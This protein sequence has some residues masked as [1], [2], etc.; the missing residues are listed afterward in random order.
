M[1]RHDLD[2]LSLLAGMIF[3]GTALVSLL[4]QGAGLESRWTWPVLLIVAGVAGLLATRRDPGPR[5]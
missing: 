1:P 5:P 4:T 3:A 2:G